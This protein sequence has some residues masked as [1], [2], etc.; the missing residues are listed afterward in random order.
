MKKNNNYVEIYYKIEKKEKQEFRIQDFFTFLLKTIA[1]MGRM[2]R[3]MYRLYP[4]M[5]SFLNL[6]FLKVFPKSH[7]L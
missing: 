2:P 1:T 7:L 3:R 4:G 6:L 5:R